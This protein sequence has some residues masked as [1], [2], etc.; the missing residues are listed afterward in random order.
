MH[1]HKTLQYIVSYNLE[2]QTYY[3]ACINNKP[4]RKA[5]S[6]I[7]RIAG[8]F[9][10][11]THFTNRKQLVKILP[12]KCLLFNGYSLQSVTICE[13]FPLENLRKANS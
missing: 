7:Y 10:G 8:Y 6:L 1:V 5:T 3:Y 9:Q 4:C 11:G 2:N 13:N 12:S